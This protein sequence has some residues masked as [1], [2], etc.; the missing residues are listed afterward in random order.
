MICQDVYCKT[1]CKKFVSP[2]FGT[3]AGIP[4]IYEKYP[5]KLQVNNHSQDHVT[6]FFKLTGHVST[7]TY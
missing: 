1:L 3:N 2:N 6:L 4:T 7:H 5:Y